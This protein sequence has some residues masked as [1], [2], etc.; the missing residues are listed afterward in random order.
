MASQDVFSDIAG[1]LAAPPPAASPEASPAVAPTN[2][3]LSD[4]HDALNGITPSQPASTGPGYDPGRE[5]ARATTFGLSDKIAAAVEGAKSWVG[6][7]GFT[8]PYERS[9]AQ[10]AKEHEAFRSENPILSPVM[11]V[12]GAIG[13]TAPFMPAAAPTLLGRMGQGATIGTVAGG[14]QGFGGSTDRPIRDTLTGA[15]V[16]LG[17]GTALP[18]GEAAATPL[19]RGFK[20]K[21]PWAFPNAAQT[22][23]ISGIKS[24]IEESEAGGGPGI[25]EMLDELRK[26]PNKPLSITDV[27]GE[28]VQS[29]AGEIARKP[30]PGRQMMQGLYGPMNPR[31][32]E[33]GSRLIQDVDDAFAA[34]GDQTS[35]WQATEDN[36]RARAQNARPLYEAAFDRNQVPFTSDRLQEFLK[37]PVLQR[38]LATGL[39][40]QRLEALADG[41]PFLP[42]DYSIHP[43]DV[44]RFF[45]GEADA[46]GNPIP[47]QSIRFSE[48]PN[49]RTLDAGKRGL[50]AMLSGNTYRN[51]YGQLTETGRAINLVRNAY[52]NEL[53]NLTGG[54]SGDYAKARAA[55]AGPSRATEM[56]RE[57]E[58]FLQT[59]PTGAELRNTVSN[60]NPSDREWYMLGAASKLR[61]LVLDTQLNAD[62]SKKLINSQGIK[63]R[64]SALFD[65][66]NTYD[67]FVNSVMAER[68]MKEAGPRI[69]GGSQ[70][71]ARV[72]ADAGH[73]Q[74]ESTFANAAT[75][76]GAFAAHEPILGYFSASR[77]LK[78]VTN[79]AMQP[80]PAV[81]A[82]IG[83]LLSR[84]TLPENEAIL[85]GIAA[86]S[87]PSSTVPRLTPGA[88]GFAA[89]IYPG[90][91]PRKSIP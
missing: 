75:A 28:P 6:G 67:Q 36:L 30:G 54:A 53:D 70:T 52:V 48:T 12:M 44:P 68:G 77:A 29:L 83:R 1:A 59:E 47:A 72:A 60:L 46:E 71:A 35:A 45:A 63:N 66:N 58:G 31:D 64:L 16:G 90:E 4:I 78:G 84:T 51:Q 21:L 33:A 49:L 39:F 86:P 89:G 19:L 24:A 81:R 42:N 56:I 15:A 20:N 82:E 62:E 14:A 65:S 7:Q 13:A 10:A 9:V 43:E 74:A 41:R 23:A 26:T 37:E 3:L 79:W 80:S 57:G 73:G 61:S 69:V 5:A 91:V 25:P 34:G 17:A 22:Q 40:N 32:V 88:A 85:Q 18:I 2:P 11:D 55:F 50:D 76:L 87:T 8:E 27:A 38:G